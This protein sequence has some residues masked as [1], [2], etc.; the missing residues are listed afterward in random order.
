M[1]HDYVMRGQFVE[2]TPPTRLVITFG[3]EHEG[4]ALDPGSTLITYELSA[5]GDG[6]LLR[7]THSGLP[8]RLV[9]DHT[10]GW[11]RYMGRLK[12]A[13]E[14]GDPGEDAIAKRESS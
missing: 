12:L 2:V 7:F 1:K 9:Y 6:T 13:A 8:E 5:D 4:G 11:T 14:G 3:W 10:R